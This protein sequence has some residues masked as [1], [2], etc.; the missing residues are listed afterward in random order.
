MAGMLVELWKQCSLTS[1]APRLNLG[2]VIAQRS[3][4]LM[5]I[6]AM[7]KNGMAVDVSGPVVFTKH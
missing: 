2:Q 1:T 6:E 4:F 3:A 7:V 5:R